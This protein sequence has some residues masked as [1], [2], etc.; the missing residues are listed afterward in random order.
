MMH[1]KEIGLDR[2]FVTSSNVSSVGYDPQTQTLEVEFLSG[3]VYQ[4]YGVPDHIYSEMMSAGSKGRFLHTYI[5]NAYPY[6]RV[7]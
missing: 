7:G 4:Y 6:S 3:A 1:R 5:R 2:R